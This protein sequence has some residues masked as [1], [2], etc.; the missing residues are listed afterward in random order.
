MGKFLTEVAE[1]RDP[2]KATD[3]FDPKDINHLKAYAHL[4]ETGVWPEGWPLGPLPHLWTIILANKL[5][6]AYLDLMGVRR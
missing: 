3:W 4:Q 5:A 6:A 1:Q 2:Y